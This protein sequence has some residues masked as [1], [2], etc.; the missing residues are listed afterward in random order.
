MSR[1]KRQSERIPR[2]DYV[3][4][5]ALTGADIGAGVLRDISATGA[6]IWV[7]HPGQVPDYFKLKIPGAPQVPRCRVRWR[8]GS[9]MG[10]EFFGPK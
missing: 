10:V 5:V 9:E 1:D 3:S 7:K 8:S 2:A 6:R 4:L